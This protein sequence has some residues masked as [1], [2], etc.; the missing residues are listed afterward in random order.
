M[1]DTVLD[2]LIIGSGFSGIGTA[3]NLKNKGITNFKIVDKGKDFGGTWR[4]NKYTGAAC[5]VRSDLRSTGAQAPNNP[6]GRHPG[7]SYAAKSRR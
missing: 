3:I 2:V 1:K 6:T 5:D 4:D 7:A